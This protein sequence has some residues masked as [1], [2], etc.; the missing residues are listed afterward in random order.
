MHKKSLNI[1]L[2]PLI[3]FIG[4]SEFWE[5]LLAFNFELS[6]VISLL[7]T[8]KKEREKLYSLYLSLIVTMLGW[9]LYFKTAF[10]VE[11]WMLSYNWIIVCFMRWYVEILYNIIKKCIESFSCFWICIYILKLLLGLNPEC[12]RITGSLFFIRWYVEILYEIIK[13]FIESFSCFWIYIY[14]LKLLLGLDP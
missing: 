3:I 6:F 10:R 12:Y 4:M 9:N 1:I 5:A 11:S 8:S 14:I 13:I 7:L 2:L